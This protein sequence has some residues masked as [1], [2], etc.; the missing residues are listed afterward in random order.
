[1]W[2]E[3]VGRS[4]LEWLVTAADLG[5]REVRNRFLAVLEKEEGK[6]YAGFTDA[7]RQTLIESNSNV[8]RADKKDEEKVRKK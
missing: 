3:T 7:S 8:L 5:H 4:G 1:M 6:S 2:R